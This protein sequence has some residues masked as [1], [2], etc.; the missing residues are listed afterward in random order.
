[1]G[2]KSSRKGKRDPTVLSEEDLKLLKSNTQY[3]EEEI[4]GWHAGFMKDCPSGQ[5][6]KKQFL[7]LYR[8]GP[9]ITCEHFS[10]LIS[11][12]SIRTA[13]QIN[14]ATSSSKPSTR[15]IT[16]GLIS[17][18]SCKRRP[19]ALAVLVPLRNVFRLAVGVSQHGNL[20]E[21]LNMAFDIYGKD[22]AR[23]V[24]R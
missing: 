13:N 8:V 20:G 22:I 4:E 6:D 12:D 24:A 23:N 7:S 14:T 10:S 15:T 16:T 9:A 11:R 3:S 18:S 2:N 17:R 5:L 19:D 21:K 1:M